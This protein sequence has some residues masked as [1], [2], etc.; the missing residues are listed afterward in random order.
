MPP[1]A[2]IKTQFVKKLSTT[3][4]S[5][6]SATGLSRLAPPALAAT[7]GPHPRQTDFVASLGGL[8]RLAPAAFTATN[9]CF[10]K[11]TA[12]RTRTV[13]KPAA[14]RTH[15]EKWETQFVKRLSTTEEST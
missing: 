4:G 9:R 15:P 14:L 1:P 13:Q 7:L 6:I 8:S 5:A 10:K 12:L 11:P 3:E 2:R